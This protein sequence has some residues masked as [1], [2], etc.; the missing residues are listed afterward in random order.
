MVDSAKQNLNGCTETVGKFE[1]E[2][3]IQK[4]T[5]RMKDIDEVKLFWKGA[6]VKRSVCHSPAQRKPRHV[7]FRAHEYLPKRGRYVQQSLDRL[8]GTEKC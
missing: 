3:R 1:N 2:S 7:H 8:F 4:G 5:G 6:K